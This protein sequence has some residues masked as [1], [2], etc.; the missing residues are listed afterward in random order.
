MNK[1]D[2]IKDDI[3]TIEDKNYFNDQIDIIINQHKDNRQTIN[4]LVFDSIACLT[5]ADRASIL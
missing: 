3:V 2:V 4:R 5:D 1:L